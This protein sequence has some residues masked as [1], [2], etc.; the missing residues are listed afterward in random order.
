[1]RKTV[2]DGSNV[3][4]FQRTALLATDGYINTSLGRV[5]IPTICLEEEAAQKLEDARTEFGTSSVGKD[6][7]A[8][9]RLDRLGIPLIEIATDSNIKSNEHAKETAA[10]IGMVLR[11]VEGVKRGLGTIRQDVN[12]SIKGHP[13][14][15][16]K[17]FQDV[18]MFIP[19]IEKEIERQQK[20]NDK[21]SEVRKA[22]PDGTT[23]FMRPMPGSARMYPETDLPLLHISRGRI[24]NLKANLPKLR[25]DI[26]E[27]LKQRG[28]NDEMIHLI[29]S[30]NKVEEF[31]SLLPLS[32][33]ANLIAK[34][35]VLWP[36]DFSR[37]LNKIVEFETDVIE[38]V[39]DAVRKN[40]IG[41][42]NVQDVLFDI[43]NGKKLE[44]ARKGGELFQKLFVRAR[45]YRSG[46]P[47]ARQ[48]H[49]GGL[50]R[51]L[52]A[53]AHL[54]G[55]VLCIA[56]ITATVQTVADGRRVGTILSNSSLL[57]R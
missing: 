40:K 54:S 1:M 49:T 32:K 33:D 3:S 29:V 46:N 41:I 8:R 37:K 21:K 4:G 48:G 42:S 15:E 39:L 36:K 11:S 9:Y 16:I 56:A 6:G 20:S 25:K 55:Q 5:G 17:G 19:T 14:V 50:P 12:I 38:S 35:L 52:G 53:V 18:K 7:Y 30:E 31:K 47:G 23:T 10:Y 43:A 13:R 45:L 44:D 28:L 2:V 57:P 24:N 34:M 27:E 51:L 22:E 26:K